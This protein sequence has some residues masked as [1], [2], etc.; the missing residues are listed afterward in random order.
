MSNQLGEDRIG[1]LQWEG[2]KHRIEV[3][4]GAW[5]SGA[6][7][8][9]LNTDDRGNIPMGRVG[10]DFFARKADIVARD[11]LGRTLVVTMGNLETR[12]RIREVGAY[13]GATK[14]T[15]EGALYEPGLVSVSVKYGQCLIDI[16]TGREEKTS[17]TASCITL[18]A[19]DILLPVGAPLSVQGPGNLARQLGITPQTREVIEGLKAYGRSFGFM[20]EAVPSTAVEVKHGN[21]KNCRGFYFYKL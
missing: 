13:E 19:A 7:S 4:L 15:S 9:V 5:L 8:E 10:R 3:L 17:K 12:A 11:L 18:R 1:L 20:G 6:K 14:H 16:A 21:S 2:E